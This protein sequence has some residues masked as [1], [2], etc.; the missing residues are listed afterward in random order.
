MAIAYS[1]LTQGTV[2][3]GHTSF[4]TA[5]ISPAANA[6]VVAFTV[7]GRTAGAATEAGAVTNGPFSQAMVRILAQQQGAGNQRIDVHRGLEAA[8]GSGTIQFSWGGDTYDNAAWVIVQFTGVNPGGLFGASAI[9]QSKVGTPSGNNVS[10]AFNS[11]VTTGN[12]TFGGYTGNTQTPVYTAGGTY[13]A[14]G[15]EWNM[16]GPSNRGLCIYN[17]AGNSPV[18]W[19]DTGTP[20]GAAGILEVA[21]AI[22]PILAEQKRIRRAGPMGRVRAAN[23]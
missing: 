14:A 2:T 13:T 12:A 6:L 4:T 7:G 16:A 20:L 3:V 8:P 21:V 19:A 11:G 17:L 23:Y 10:L 22:D 15:V 1:L 5:S 9:A 18:Q